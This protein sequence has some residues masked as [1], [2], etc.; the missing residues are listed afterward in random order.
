MAQPTKLRVIIVGSGLA[1]LAAARV[2]REHHNVIIYERAGPDAATGGQGIS[3]APNAVKILESV[4][5]D[6]A[7]AGGVVTSGYQ[8]YNKDGQ[9]RVDFDVDFHA[10]YGADALTFKRSDFRDE[11]L[12]LATA[13]ADE[14]G[15][16]VNSVKAV[17]NNGVVEIDAEEGTVVLQDGSTDKGDVVISPYLALLVFLLNNRN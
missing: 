9:L 1:G 12:R 11:L 17:F 5:F 6:R 2:V 14:L 8:S 16:S 15:S 13:S 3:L 10:R 7:R 4:G